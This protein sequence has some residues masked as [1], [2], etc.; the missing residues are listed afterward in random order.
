MLEYGLTY[1]DIAYLPSKIRTGKYKTTK[2]MPKDLNDY[3]LSANQKDFELWQLAN[4]RLDQ[5]KTQLQEECGADIVAAALQ[6]FDQL[7][8]EV[9]AECSDYVEWYKSHGYS[10]PYTYSGTPGLGDESGLGFRCVRHVARRFMAGADPKAQTSQ[11]K[12]I[13]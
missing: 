4:K 5:K 2:D 13:I 10:A 6:K 12:G 7:L 9:A 8:H 1:E 3:I 11:A